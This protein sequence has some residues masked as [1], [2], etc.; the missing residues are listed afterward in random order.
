MGLSIDTFGGWNTKETVE[1]LLF[2]NLWNSTLTFE[3]TQVKVEL[4]LFFLK[5]KNNSAKCGG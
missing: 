4:R 3:S 1:I 5:E 2:K